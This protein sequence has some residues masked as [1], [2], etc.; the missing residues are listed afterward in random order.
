[1]I[2]TVPDGDGGRSHP[3]D[4]ISDALEAE[5]QLVATDPLGREVFLLTP[6]AIANASGARTYPAPRRLL[7]SPPAYG[8]FQRCES[9]GS[10]Q[11]SCRC[12][13][14]PAWR[15]RVSSRPMIPPAFWTRC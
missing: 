11:Y 4:V 5:V 6:G 1:M 13:P 9:V 12:A 2:D 3:I 7:V 14:Y 10:R 15:L 8:T